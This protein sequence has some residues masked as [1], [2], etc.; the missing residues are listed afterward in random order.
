MEPH[1]PKQPPSRNE[2]HQ[3]PVR[4]YPSQYQSYKSPPS[5]QQLY[6]NTFS[7]QTPSNL[8]T[9]SMKRPNQPSSCTSP[10]TQNGHPV[11]TQATFRFPPPSSQ[12]DQSPQFPY[13]QSYW[14]TPPSGVGVY[15]GGVTVSSSTGAVRADTRLQTQ[16][17]HS[18]DANQADYWMDEVNF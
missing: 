4:S 6:Q 9:R 8:R 11:S 18:S 1:P 10:P 17:I 3:Q 14:T 5:D 16:V 15:A 2:S 13:P 7:Q 12:Q